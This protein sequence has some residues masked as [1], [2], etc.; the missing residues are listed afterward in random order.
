MRVY[1]YMERSHTS[2]HSY[3]QDC[4]SD[5]SYIL[6]INTP[7][8]LD[9][10]T[11][12]SMA[13]RAIWKCENWNSAGNGQNYCKLQYCWPIFLS[14]SV[15]WPEEIAGR[16]ESRKWLRLIDLALKQNQDQEPGTRNQDTTTV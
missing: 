7:R 9:G 6:K 8:E 4:E 16:F 13:S 12:R 5:C 15:D 3:G 1:W 14:S 10:Q 11:V 2:T